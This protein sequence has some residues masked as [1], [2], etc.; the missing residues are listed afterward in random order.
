MWETIL[1]VFDGGVLGG[2]FG[3][4]G[5]LGTSW[6]KYKADEKERA[7]KL[8]ENKDKRA[9]SLKMIKAETEATVREVEANVRRDQILMDGR[10]DIEESKGRNAAIMK[11]SENTV[12]QSLVERMM[13]NKS[14]W[15]AW[16]TAPVSLLITFIHGFV[17]ISGRLVRITVTYGAVVFSAYVTWMAFD[18]YTEL[19]IVMTAPQLYSIIN[20][21]LQ[22]LTFTTSTVIGFWFMD[23]SMSRKFQNKH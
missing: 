5:G 13:F 12:A 10:A 7:F 16:V 9:H 17:D 15:S 22:L 1:S 21:M 2:L 4:V 11:I 18:M 20:T 19:G 8:A 23:K 3:I 6:I 14:A